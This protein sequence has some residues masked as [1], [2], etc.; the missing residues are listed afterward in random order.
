MQAAYLDWCSK[1][2]F[3]LWQPN[4]VKEHKEKAKA[5]ETPCI[6]PHLKPKEEEIV[7][8]PAK[9]DKELI[10]RQENIFDELSADEGDEGP[11]EVMEQHDK[12]G[13]IRL[14][15]VKRE[16]GMCPCQLLG[17][18]PVDQAEVLKEFVEPFLHSIA[19]DEKDQKR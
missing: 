8:D 14:I 11:L 13:R 7:Y 16:A 6:D 5:D 4:D 3:E 19:S 12:I 18:M 2:N 9:P 17:D 15:S 10:A 1:N